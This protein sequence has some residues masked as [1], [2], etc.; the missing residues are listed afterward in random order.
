MAA[1]IVGLPHLLD[2]VA[3]KQC[4]RRGIAIAAEL[5]DRKFVAAKARYR[6]MLGDASAE[7]ARHF[8]QQGVADRVAEGVVDFLEMSE[9]E[10]K[11]CELVAPLGEAQGLCKLL[12]EQRP[13]R[14]IG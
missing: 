1:D 9:I 7:P 6:I 11:C 4:H 5:D 8:P 10:A 2:D 3:G 13:V 12:P 14:Q